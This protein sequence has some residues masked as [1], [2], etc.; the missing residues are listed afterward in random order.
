MRVGSQCL[1]KL[2]ATAVDDNGFVAMLRDAARDAG[3]EVTLLRTSG[4]AADHALSPS[5]LEAG[6]SERNRDAYG[7]SPL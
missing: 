5:Y 1:I 2:C 4:A 6:S 3:R 7:V